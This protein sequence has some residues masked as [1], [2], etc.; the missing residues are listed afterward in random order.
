MLLLCYLYV[1]VANQVCTIVV[2]LP[3]CYCY[4]FTTSYVC[5]IMLL[6]LCYRLNM[7]Y[8][9]VV[10]VPLLLVK[11][12]LLCYCRYAIMLLCCWPSMCYYCVV[13]QVC[14]VIII[15]G[16]KHFKDLLLFS[17]NSYHLHTQERTK[18]SKIV[19]KNESNHEK[20]GGWGRWGWALALFT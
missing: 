1:I 6:L 16:R 20:H 14:Y 18:G 12:V 17:Y 11:Y 10:V 8:C 9:V 5:I 3:L 13:G 19:I 2:L 4:C 15:V 7:C